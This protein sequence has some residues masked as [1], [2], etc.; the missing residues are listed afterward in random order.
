M[1][2]TEQTR[3]WGQAWVFLALAIALHV[4]DEAITGFLPLYNS[5]VG[6]LRETWSWIPLPTFSFRVWLAG[7]AAGV[8]VIL[9][10]SPLI[11]AGK[12]YL[13]P[14]AFG[15]GVLMVANA[16]V[17]IGASIYLRTLAPGVLSSPILLLAALSVLTT[18]V[19]YRESARD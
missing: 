10:I 15:L 2:S 9:G 6:S 7:L 3:R 1:I 16:L 4:A 12:T 8:L 17:H 5:I 14:V 18:T 11:F 19:R 13:R